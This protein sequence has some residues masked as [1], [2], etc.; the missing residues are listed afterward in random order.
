MWWAFSVQGFNACSVFFQHAANEEY[1]AY[2]SI[3]GGSFRSQNWF[4]ILPKYT[5]EISVITNQSD[6]ETPENLIKTVEGLIEDLK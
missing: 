5:M 2:F 4:F 1:A 6:F 3:H